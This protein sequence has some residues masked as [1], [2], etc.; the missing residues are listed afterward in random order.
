MSSALIDLTR[1]GPIA[2]MTLNRPERL[3]ALPD[4]GDGDELAAVCAA[5]NADAEVRAVVLTGAG[6]AFSAG[7]DLRAMAARTGLFEP[8]GEAIA[9][10]YRRV[11]HGVIRAVD[12]LE[13]PVIA[14][15][16]GPAMGLGCDLAGLADIRIAST[17]AR[18]GVPFVRLGLVPGDGGAWLLPRR[19]GQAR[20]AWM[21][22]TGETI[23]AQTALD[24]GLVNEVVEPEALMDRAFALAGQLADQPPLALRATKALLRQAR[25]AGLDQLLE[26]SAQTQG[27][28]HETADH[29]EGVAAVL[30]RRPGRF[31]GR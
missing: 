20:A 8:P 3:N 5:L 24:W 21:L 15:V 4:L 7:G 18:F 13:M 23:E 17:D 27:R 14:A 28:L 26:Q 29:A 25:E 1:R 31:E 6:R 10:R 2:V 16:N 12:G 9:E 30:E 19:I 22:F 11:V